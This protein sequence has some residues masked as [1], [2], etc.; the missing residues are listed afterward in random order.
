MSKSKQQFKIHQSIIFSPR[1]Y[2]NFALGLFA[3]LCAYV[4]AS[5][6][7]PVQTSDASTVHITNNTSDYFIDITSA[8]LL[9]LSVTASPS[10]QLAYATDSINVTTNS[11]NG[12]KLYVSTSGNDNNIYQNGSSSTA[13]QGYFYPTTGTIASPVALIQN[14]WGFA[15]N[16][17]QSTSFSTAFANTAEYVNDTG[18]PTTSSTWAAV[19]TLANSNQAKISELDGASN[20]PNGTNLDIYY[21]INASTTL[22]DGSYS[23]EIT[24]TAISEGVNQFPTMQDFTA[25]QCYNMATNTSINLSDSRDD[26]YYRVT[27]MAD[28]HCWMTDNL[29]L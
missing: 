11:I 5:T 10:G 13:S 3:F 17:T 6:F 4:V 23:T 26:K 29:A 8:D 9:E 27:K 24:Y 21:G 16:K 20:S 28:G 7:T 18:A 12:Y 2:R 22:P 25:E 14:T 19:P 1:A 15:L